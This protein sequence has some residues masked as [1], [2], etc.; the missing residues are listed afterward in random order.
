MSGSSGQWC[1]ADDIKELREGMHDNN[2]PEGG[3]DVHGDIQM[4]PEVTNV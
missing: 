3:L 2:C 4:I 1:C